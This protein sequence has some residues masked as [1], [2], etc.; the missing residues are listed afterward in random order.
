FEENVGQG[1]P[2]VAFLARGPGYTVLLT[3]DGASFYLHGNAGPIAQFQMRWPKSAA[4]R[5]IFALKPSE[6]ISNYLI[7]D[8]PGHWRTN[9]RNYEMVEYRNL[10]PAVDL[11]FHGNH[12]QLE[13]DVA[14][15]PGA[16]ISRVSFDFQGINRV[17]INDDGDLVLRTPQGDL[18]Q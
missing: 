5:R 8:R 6:T 13:Y 1:P 9:I 15:T 16:D 2:G 10:V 7:G 12:R 3:D 4:K 14:L 17:E 11:I 18:I